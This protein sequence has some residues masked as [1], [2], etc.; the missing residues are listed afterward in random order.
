MFMGG[1]L[2]GCVTVADSHD[3]SFKREVVVEP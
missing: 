2:D 3:L 1:S